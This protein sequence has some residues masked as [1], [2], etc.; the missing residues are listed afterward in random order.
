M[1]KTCISD[2][3]IWILSAELVGA[4]SS[5]LAGSFSDFFTRYAEPPLLPPAWVFPVVWTILYALM[6]WGACLVSASSESGCRGALAVYRIQLVLNFAWS[7][8]FF[9]FELL[10]ASAV[11]LAALLVMVLL[12]VILFFKCSRKAAL[13]NLP[14]LL[15]AGF[16]LYLNVATASANA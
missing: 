2:C 10:W 9:R 11:E 15:W 14:Y 12:M 5:L 16:A 1:K 6:G 7:I 4:L 13:L 3:F 8:L